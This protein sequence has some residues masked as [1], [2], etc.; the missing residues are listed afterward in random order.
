MK[1][2]QMTELTGDMRRILVLE[3]LSGGR[4]P[5][6]QSRENGG[7]EQD[8]SMCVVAQQSHSTDLTE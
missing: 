7:R 5:W 3:T 8:T 4:S 1:P 2:E 6:R